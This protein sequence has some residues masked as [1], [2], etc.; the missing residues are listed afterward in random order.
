MAL[1]QRAPHDRRMTARRRV[2][3]G[4]WI[5]GLDE[6]DFA[7]CRIRDFS[8]AGA[9]VEMEDPRGLPG[10]ACFLDMRN[11]LAYEARVAWRQGSEVGLEFRKV[12]RFDEVPS[13]VLRHRIELLC[14]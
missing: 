5:A 2:L 7:A 9:R 12:Y 11:R 3:W 6:G 1:A 10:Q 4:C 13:P 8:P 14:R